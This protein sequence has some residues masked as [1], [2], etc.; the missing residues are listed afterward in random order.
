MLRLLRF[1]YITKMGEVVE[2]KLL[3]LLY[4]LF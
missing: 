1:T 3:I 2:A 4:I